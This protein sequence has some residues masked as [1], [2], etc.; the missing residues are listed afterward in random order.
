MTLQH[1]VLTRFPE[2]PT[3]E[4][5]AEMARRLKA[6][7]ET[8]P[9]I[10]ALRVGPDL[11]GARTQGYHFLLYMEFADA[12]GLKAYSEHPAHHEYVAWVRSQEGA[13]LA[14]DYLLSDETVIV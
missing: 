7:S 10:Q 3:A 1:V 4:V 13:T 2:P 11:T 5:G 9:G 8:I 14:F 6:L 12:D